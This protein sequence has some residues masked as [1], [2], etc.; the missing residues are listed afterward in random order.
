MRR[1]VRVVLSAVVA[2]LVARAAHARE[3]W[4]LVTVTRGASWEINEASGA[5][6]RSG[7]VL[8]GVLKDAKDGQPD[9]KI[10]IELAGEHAEAMFWFVSENDEGTTLTGTYTKAPGA[11]ATHGPEQIQ[12]VNDHQ[13]IGL[14][15]GACEGLAVPR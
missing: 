1:L 15:R 9:N 5:L 13:Y 4:E 3:E 2:V 7:S 11:T 12:L 8:E 6:K 10:R 14:A